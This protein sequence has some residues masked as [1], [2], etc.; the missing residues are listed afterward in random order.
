[1]S[2]IIGFL[3]SLLLTFPSYIFIQIYLDGVSIA[4][5]FTN[6]VAGNWDQLMTV[7][8]SA[9]MEPINVILTTPP[10][11]LRILFAYL[12]WV[13]V[14]FIVGFFFKKRKAALGGLITTAFIYWVIGMVNHMVIRGDTFGP[15]TLTEANIF[16]GTFIVFAI[17]LIIG[18]L[19]GLISPF[20]KDGIPRSE[21]E[22]APLETP[23]P[24]YMPTESPSRDE[25]METNHQMPS[26]RQT[27][28]DP[29]AC[30]YCGSYVD[31]ETEYCSVC[32]NRV[33]DDQ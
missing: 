1:M 13:V 11:F 5:F 10:V 30:E 2:F 16:Y 18:T 27:S 19:S 4:N 23:G 3:I 32:G 21:S 6:I 17:I 26:Q 22:P 31:T 14:A 25:Y 33:F 9:L 29:M 24:Y 15:D 12:P 8:E 20:K 7:C 28:P